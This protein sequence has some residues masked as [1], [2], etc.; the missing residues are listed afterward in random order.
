MSLTLRQNVHFLTHRSDR[1]LSRTFVWLALFL[2]YP[3]PDFG[4]GIHPT[5]L[6]QIKTVMQLP[7]HESMIRD[8]F[9]MTESVARNILGNQ[10]SM[11]N[12]WSSSTNS[13]RGHVVRDR[14]WAGFESGWFQIYAYLSSHVWGAKKKWKPIAMETFC[15]WRFPV[16][17]K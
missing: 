17:W 5:I 4:T 11:S 2:I 10:L 13:L 1:N 12:R 16:E 15:H 7:E 14:E 8:G 3:S 6:F 9:L